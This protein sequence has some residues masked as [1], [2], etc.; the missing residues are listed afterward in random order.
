[1]GGNM[2]NRYIVE[3]Q[4]LTK[5]Y[6]GMK[7]LWNL[8][9]QLHDHNIIGLIGRNGSG[10]TTFLKMCAGIIDC[11]E[12]SLNVLGSSP[13]N[14]LPVLKQIVYSSSVVAHEPTLTLDKII[15]L[16]RI[17][18]DRFDQVFAYKLMSHFSLSRE[19]RYGELSTGMTS[20]F[21]FICALACRAELTLLDEPVLGMDVKVRHDI[22]QILL[23]EFQENPRTIVV[24]SHILT[25]LEKV[26]SEL[27]L[28]EEG[29]LILYEEVDMVRSMYIRVDGE[30]EKLNRF[31]EGKEVMYLRNGEMNSY[32]ILK[33]NT[34]DI[35]SYENMDGIKLSSVPLE[36]L[37][38]C[39]T[40]NGK[41]SDLECLW[42]N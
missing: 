23:R 11:S 12:G 15:A 29:K 7:A 18:Y 6:N 10:K 39:L 30:P 21:N 27:M 32:A 36:E 40:N 24:S 28:I 5:N 17:M 41:E 14:N 31:C 26:V 2:D 8:N 3:T 20:T 1:M 22:Y 16:F 19:Y 25:E 37:C 4:N 34:R 38:I 9:V 33:N 35:K 42:K 13:I